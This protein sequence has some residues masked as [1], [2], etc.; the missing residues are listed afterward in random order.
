MNNYGV[1]GV[2]VDLTWPSKNMAGNTMARDPPELEERA[3][4]SV[5]EGERGGSGQW[6]TRE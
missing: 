1:Q 2:R 6:I 3:R 4:G 5:C